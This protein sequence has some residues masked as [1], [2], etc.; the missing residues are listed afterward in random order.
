[1]HGVESSTPI[2]FERYR[3]DS[4]G[5]LFSITEPITQGAHTGES[6]W[7]L[8]HNLSAEQ[9][10]YMTDASPTERAFML[11]SNMTPR[12]YYIMC[13][14]AKAFLPEE[15]RDVVETTKQ[16]MAVP[17]NDVPAPDSAYFSMGNA[18]A[19]LISDALMP[20]RPHSGRGVNNG[21]EQAWSLAQHIA[22]DGLNASTLEEWSSSII[23]PL[24]EWVE[25][26]QG[27]ARRNGLGIPAHAMTTERALTS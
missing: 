24:N 19:A 11:P 1:M 17:M 7:T 16:I 3:N 18:H 26:G 6:D 13:R 4:D 21:I 9:F 12:A 27:R 8:Y 15:W 22:S 23:P 14:I 2:G 10:E 20:V 5:I 25:L